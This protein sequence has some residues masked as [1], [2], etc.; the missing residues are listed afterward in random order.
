[1]GGY[2]IFYLFI[3]CAGFQSCF[4]AG[5]TQVE[6]Q[7]QSIDAQIKELQDKKRGF[8]AKAL[9]HQDQ[10]ERLQFENRNFLEA[11]RH[12]ELAEEN[13][14]KANFI[15]MQIDKLKE[16]KKTLL[17]STSGLFSYENE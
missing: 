8:E 10:A 17:T 1:M 4:G 11:K 9:R 14:E 15:Q 12:M 16:K 5:S 6:S 13:R 2:R 3:L 7:I